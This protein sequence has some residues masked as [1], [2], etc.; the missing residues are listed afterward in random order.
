[1]Q[2]VPH[3]LPICNPLL[4]LFIWLSQDFVPPEVIE[5]L[6]SSTN[7][8]IQ[9]LFQARDLIPDRASEQEV[10][11]LI[12]CNTRFASSERHFTFHNF[13]HLLLCICSRMDSF[14][15]RKAVNIDSPQ[16]LLFI[17]SRYLSKSCPYKKGIDAFSWRAIIV[18]GVSGI[19]ARGMEKRKK[20]ENVLHQPRFHPLPS[21]HGKKML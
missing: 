7:S 18:V 9:E 14:H 13:G 8:L 15:S 5:L 1:M 16:S 12:S 3:C 19:V 10:I 17:N 4:I 2:R 20:S 21:A 6:Q 11:S